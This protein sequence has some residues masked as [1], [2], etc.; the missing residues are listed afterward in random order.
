[1]PLTRFVVREF[2]N[3]F[4][5]AAMLLWIMISYV[6]HVNDSRCTPRVKVWPTAD[7]V[8]I[9][10]TLGLLSVSLA[11]FLAFSTVSYPC[12]P[13]PLITAIVG[14]SCYTNWHGFCTMTLSSTSSS[15]SIFRDGKLIPGVYKI[16]NL[17]AETYLDVHLHSME[18]CCRPARDLEGKRGFVRPCLHLRFAHLITGKW[19][20]ARLGDGYAMWRV[21]V[22]MQLIHFLPHVLN[23]VEPRLIR[24]TLI[25]FAAR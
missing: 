19:R 13:K 18:L 4:N 2:S 6:H 22:S 24:G 11:I 9:R 20:I 23:D 12:T 8:G 25:N 1:M 10:T 3:I 5:I 17:Y 21:S 7:Q 15:S 14:H 16:Q